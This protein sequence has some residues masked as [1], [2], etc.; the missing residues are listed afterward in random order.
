MPTPSAL[1]TRRA[2]LVLLLRR[3]ALYTGYLAL[4][5]TPL[6]LVLLGPH[7]P[8]R[9]FWLD[10]SFGLGL[11]GLGMLALQFLS[12]A[13]INGVDAPYGIDSVMR[14][15][16]Q[17]AFVAVAFIAL[18]PTLLLGARWSI[19]WPIVNPLHAPS[20]V[21][22]GQAA[23]L[24]LVFLVVVSVLRL[25]LGVDYEV[26]RA[27]HGL[28]AVLVT[29]FALVH[30]RSVGVYVQRG[31]WKPAVFTVFSLVFVSL[32]AYVRVV[33]PLAR[34]RR[35]YVV[36]EMQPESGGAVTIRLR[37]VRG[38]GLRF[39]AGQFSWLTLSSTAFSQN[40]HPFSISSSAARP[41]C[42]EFTV[43]QLGDFTSR[44]HEVPPGT[45]AYLDGPFGNFGVGWEAATQLLLVAGGIGVTPIMSILRT[46]VDTGDQRA[47]TVVYGNNDWESA[48]FG[49]ELDDMTNR[50]N[51]KIVHVLARGHEGWEG[52]VGF[53]TIDVLRR[54]LPADM[55][56]LQSYVC[57]PPPM[58]SA[59]ER[60]LADAGV[61]HRQIHSEIFQ[62]V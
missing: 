52:E 4:A 19:Y 17:I 8:G 40:E 26:W 16:R 44:V 12:V 14:Y 37:P 32:L 51:M 49:D 58:M 48:V 15:H 61:P 45:R 33:R 38:N 2:S 39:R 50:L 46:M 57:G 62:F 60:A 13:R 18:H 30:V 24:L 59:V 20:R 29:G 7:P 55:S 22:W 3:I 42:V 54:V 23:F 53:I 35:P 41:D 43:K 34:L 27:T 5:V 6:A 31:T 25:R 10:F 9:G 47:V 11:V 56:G 21:Q 1:A 28:L 36:E